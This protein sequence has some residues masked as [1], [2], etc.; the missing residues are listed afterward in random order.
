MIEFKNV[1]YNYF[2]KFYSLYNFSYTFN[3][4]NYALIGDYIDGNLNVIRLLSKLDKL[5]KGEIFING[6]N[7]T[8]LNYKKDINIAYL[9][10]SPVFFEHKTVL[11]NL[12]YPLKSRR[13]KKCDCLSICRN[14]LENFGWKDKENLKVSTLSQTEKLVLSLIRA[15]TRN[16]DILLCEDIFDSV[17]FN[18]LQKLS[19]TTTILA[20]DNS[21]APNNFVEIP[22]KLGTIN[23]EVNS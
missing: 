11:K 5:Y 4:G 13:L 8:K 3:A 23:K 14:A 7:I 1:S 19:A 16:L 17:D 6:S 2:T 18:L 21:P 20:L 9:S 12:I 22:I 15:S 10:K